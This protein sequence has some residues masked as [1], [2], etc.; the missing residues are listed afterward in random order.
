MTDELNQEIK[1]KPKKSME[2]FKDLIPELF[3][4]GMF[5]SELYEE[6]YVPSE[7]KLKNGDLVLTNAKEVLKERERFRCW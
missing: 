4:E 5:F 1:I 7:Y 3:E 2:M 6:F